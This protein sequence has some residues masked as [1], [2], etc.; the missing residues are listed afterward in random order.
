MDSIL[1]YKL[2]NQTEEQQEKFKSLIS[3]LTNQLKG[4]TYSEA[5]N[6]LEYVKIQLE[7]NLTLN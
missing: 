5:K 7:H 2:S 4:L 6:A 3:N 1:A